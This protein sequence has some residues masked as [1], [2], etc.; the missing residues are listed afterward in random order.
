MVGSRNLYRP[1]SPYSASRKTF[2]P[3]LAQGFTLLEVLVT[4]VVLS[5]GLLGVAGFQVSGLKS[6][7]SSYLRSQATL[8]AYEIMDRMRANREAAAAG[9]YDRAL[10]ALS[11]LTTLGGNASIAEIDR[12]DWYRNLN[13]ALPGAQGAI[14]CDAD[15][16]CTVTVQWDDARAAG[17]TAIKQQVVAAR[18]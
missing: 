12:Y 18:L 17:G 1:K 7:D 16:V 4:V 13:A 5:V 6:N 2:T 10:S 14:D 3:R 9:D 15:L 8:Y 11:G